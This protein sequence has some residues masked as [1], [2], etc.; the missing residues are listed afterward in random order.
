MWKVFGTK[1]RNCDGL[2]RRNFLELGAPLLGL[3]LADMLAAG[4]TAA[5]QPMLAK[6]TRPKSLIVFWTHGGMSQQD[7]YDMKPEA[8]A[9][10]R[11]MYRPVKTTVPGIVVGERFA[12]QSQVMQHISLVRSVHHENG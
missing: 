8:P 4:A 5:D 9:E 6:P 11:G 7:T 10:Y 1:Y 2:S 12:L 3:G